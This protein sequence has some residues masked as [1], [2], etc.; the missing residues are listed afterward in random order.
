V[1]PVTQM[2]T[3][4]PGS[5]QVTVPVPHAGHGEV[6]QDADAKKLRQTPSAQTWSAAQPVPQIGLLEQ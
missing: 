2:G 5:A 3:V 1:L 4:V 6:V